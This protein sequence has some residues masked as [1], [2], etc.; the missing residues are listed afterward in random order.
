MSMVSILDGN[1]PGSQNSL[2]LALAAVQGHVLRYPKV[3]W[4]LHGIDFFGS[5]SPPH[6]PKI[7]LFYSAHRIVPKALDLNT[8]RLYWSISPIDCDNSNDRAG[9][10]NATP[11]PARA[12]LGDYNPIDW[13]SPPLRFGV[14]LVVRWWSVIIPL[15]CLCLCLF[16]LHRGLKCRYRL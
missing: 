3:R 4:F 6:P 15:L 10:V 5:A 2:N 12:L 16:G 11:T 7:R 1:S 13:D 14:S 8:V 9:R